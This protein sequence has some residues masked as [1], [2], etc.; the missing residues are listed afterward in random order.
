MQDILE[1]LREQIK[2]KKMSTLMVEEAEKVVNAIV[3]SKEDA[4]Y[5]W[6]LMPDW[7]KEQPEDLG[8]TMYGTFSAIGD[9]EV[10]DKVKK[11]LFKQ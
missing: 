7:V 8:H 6:S 2:D 10:C 11:I 1:Y 4:D 9:K 3:I 5:I